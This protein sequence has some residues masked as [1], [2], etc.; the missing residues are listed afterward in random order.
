MGGFPLLVTAPL[1]P[2]T[3]S[4]ITIS[5]T[6]KTFFPEEEGDELNTGQSPDPIA[7]LWPG[8]GT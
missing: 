5:S 1:P 4:Y 7:H 2:S 3:Q 6:G 8:G